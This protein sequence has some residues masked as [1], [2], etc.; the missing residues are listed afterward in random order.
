M[1][2]KLSL[3]LENK[4]EI[5]KSFLKKKEKNQCNLS[6][7]TIRKSDRVNEKEIT[8][9]LISEDT[10]SIKKNYNSFTCIEE[11]EKCSLCNICLVKKELKCKHGFC[12]NCYEDLIVFGSVCNVCKISFKDE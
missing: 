7:K 1:L 9:I 5:L 4:R 10:Y 8:F 12:Q 11:K 2:I 3:F 6:S